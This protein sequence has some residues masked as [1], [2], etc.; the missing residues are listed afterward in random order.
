MN[1]YYSNFDDMQVI[2]VG[3]HF[4]LDLTSGGDSPLLKAG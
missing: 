3:R 1:K 4:D 2:S